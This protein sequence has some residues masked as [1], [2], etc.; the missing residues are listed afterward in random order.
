MNTMKIILWTMLQNRLKNLL[1][2]ADEVPEQARDYLTLAGYRKVL[3]KALAK[4]AANPPGHYH[5]PKELNNPFDR[6]AQIVF[7]NGEYQLILNPNNKLHQ[8]NKDPKGIVAKGTL[9]TIKPAVRLDRTTDE[10]LVVAKIHQS[11]EEALSQDV[12][13]ELRYNHEVSHPSCLTFSKGCLYNKGQNYKATLYAPRADCNLEN[14][15]TLN[16]Q[17]TYET[18]LSILIDIMEALVFMHH[19]KIGHGDLNIFNIVMINNTPKIID[20]EKSYKNTDGNPEHA[21][22][23]IEDVIDFAAIACEVLYGEENIEFYESIPSEQRIQVIDDTYLN[24]SAKIKATAVLEALKQTKEQW[25]ANGIERLTPPEYIE[26]C[27][28]DNEDEPSKTLKV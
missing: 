21:H 13:D 8:G 25:K 17:A 27:S 3:Q 12:D 26:E 23:M 22:I 4:I 2:Q 20:F 18:R 24:I 5:C 10:P 28:S 15:V 19:K 1:N 7:L 9:K 11:N 6:S 14:W 16:S